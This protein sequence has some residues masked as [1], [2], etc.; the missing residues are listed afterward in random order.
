MQKYGAIIFFGPPGS[1]KGTQAKLLEQT[2][3][4]FHFSTGNIFRNLDPKTTVGKKVRGLIDKGNF[5]PDDL[6][7]E[8]FDETLDDL[9]KK[10]KYNPNKQI[11]ILDGIPRTLKQINHIKNKFYIQKI[12][13]LKI[14]E[15]LIIER[16]TRKRTGME[17]RKD[18]K[19][20]DIV[21]KRFKTYKKETL[22]V[23]KHFD[24]KIIIKIDGSKSVKEIN[25]IILKK[26]IAF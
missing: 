5:V 10:E 21:K 1:G 16:I 11:I 23:I 9:I 6:A 25:K 19:N 14:N 15:K 13:Y 2:G 3:N 22:P 4:F 20:V 7:L 8:L 24:K 17:S 26:S 12:F 18:D